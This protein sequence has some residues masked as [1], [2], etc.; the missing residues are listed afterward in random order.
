MSPRN[1]KFSY[2]HDHED[3]D[4]MT[5]DYRALTIDRRAL[6]GLYS[7]EINFVLSGR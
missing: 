7:K 1:H 4:E 3:D 2:E 5:Q 6:P